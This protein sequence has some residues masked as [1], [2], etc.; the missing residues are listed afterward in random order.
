L[1]LQSAIS[2]YSMHAAK[3]RCLQ[4]P[5]LASVPSARVLCRALH[6]S[7]PTGFAE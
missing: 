6:F 3:L 1:V 7:F 5:N 4:S 2:L